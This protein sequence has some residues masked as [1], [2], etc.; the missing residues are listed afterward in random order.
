MTFYHVFST[1]S[2]NDRFI[3]V[4]SGCYQMQ[5]FFV[6]NSQSINHSLQVTTLCLIKAEKCSVASP[7][8]ASLWSS[9]PSL[10]LSLDFPGPKKNAGRQKLSNAKCVFPSWSAQVKALRGIWMCLQIYYWSLC[11]LWMLIHGVTW[12]NRVKLCP[13]CKICETVN[14]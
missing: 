2:V 3:C 4:Q 14:K 10:F 6:F 11:L 12:W 1:R 9:F 7:K 13:L 8:I 5:L